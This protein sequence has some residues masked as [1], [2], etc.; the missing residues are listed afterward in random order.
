MKKT[1][2]KFDYHYLFNVASPSLCALVH[3]RKNE[4]IMIIRD[5]NFDKKKMRIYR[6]RELSESTKMEL[7][8]I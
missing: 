2:G 4:D 1:S 8:L 6:H 3:S 7:F 5:A